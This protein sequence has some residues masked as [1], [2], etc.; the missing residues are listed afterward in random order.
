MNNILNCSKTYLKFSVNLIKMTYL[1]SLPYLSRTDLWCA[2]QLKTTHQNNPAMHLM[3]FLSLFFNLPFIVCRTCFFSFFFSVPL[4]V[5]LSHDE[6]HLRRRRRGRNNSRL[7]HS[8]CKKWV[9]DSFAKGVLNQKFQML[10]KLGS[11]KL[12]LLQYFQWQSFFIKL[13]FC[14]HQKFHPKI[15]SYFCNTIISQQSSSISRTI[16]SSTVLQQ[17]CRSIWYIIMAFD[18]NLN[19]LPRNKNLSFFKCHML[20]MMKVILWY[21]ENFI[22][23]QNSIQMVQI[24]LNF[25][26]FLIFLL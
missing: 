4:P 22:M 5:M 16:S 3:Q 10:V 2:K 1:F 17:H 14:K 20:K 15:W 6:T 26:K 11:S 7:P 13:L 8:R 24:R 23:K 12:Y 9:M 25:P 21:L 19:V 18:E